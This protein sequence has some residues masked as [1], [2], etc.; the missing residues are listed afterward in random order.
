MQQALE[1]VEAAYISIHTLSPQHA[2]TAG[3]GFM[4]VEMN[5]L[6]NIVAACRTNGVRRLI[7]ITS[8]GIVPDASSEWT[9]K[10]WETEQFLLNSGLDVTAIR[11]GQIVGVG[12]QGFNMMMGQARRRVALVIGSGQQKF[13]NIAL[14]DLVYYLVGVLNDPRAYGKCY[15][16]GCDDIL[17]SDQMIDVAAEVLGRNYP[18]KIHLPRVLLTA[19]APLIERLSKVPKGALKGLL[20][21]MKTD[22][23]GD[24]M[25]IRTILPRPPLVIGAV[26]VRAVQKATS[27]TPIVFS[28]VVEPVGDGLAT[29][30]QRP[31]GNATGVTTFDPHQAV[32]QVDLL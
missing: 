6:R 9:R 4:E 22:L 19:L 10:R 23:V 25:P 24:P 5:G 3:Q 20:D 29:N 12:G 17:T 30:L 1:S 15:D 21:G 27:T 7:Y 8:L 26:T 16:V 2:S 31:G 11:P 28:V 32:A 18:V 14:D 13:R